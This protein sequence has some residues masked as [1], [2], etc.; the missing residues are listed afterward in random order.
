MRSWFREGAEAFGAACRALEAPATSAPEER[1]AWARLLARHGW[2]TFY[3]GHQSEARRLLE[4]ALAALRAACEPGELVFPLNYLAAVCR[5]LGEYERAETLCRESLAIAETTGDAY[6]RAVVCNI[7][8]QI[9]FERGDHAAAGEWCRASLAIERQIGNEWSMSFSLTT[10]STVASAG[11]DHAE[12][13]RLL[14]ESLRIREAMRDPRGV[15]LCL[16]QLGAS[17]LALGEPAEALAHFRRALDLFREIGNT[18]GA[19]TTLAH[20]GR[21]AAQWRA[22]AA[23]TR[24]LQEAL[25]LALATESAPLLAEVAAS[26]APLL[27]QAGEAAWSAEVERLGAGT[28]P[29]GATR[30]TADR[31]LAWWWPGEPA[32]T[33][34]E[35]LA[36][37]TPPAAPAPAARAGFPA[38]LTAREVEVLRLVAQGLTDAQVADRLVL[39]PRTVSTHLTSIYGKL[40]V[41]S[42]AAATRFAVEQGLA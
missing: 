4:R 3:L 29:L 41:S 23:A 39:S 24:V 28:P 18:W 38:G 40:Q 25:R 35:A 19:A 33:L 34:E 1:R 13:R 20:L 42:R 21:L 7:L 11:G 2:F 8:G 22:P 5:Y 16:N 26:F 6:G 31:L 14:R 36:S 32:R 37:L 27:R 17:T 9:A 12:A 15:A 10:L 30:Q